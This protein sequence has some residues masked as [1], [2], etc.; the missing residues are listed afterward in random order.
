MTLLQDRPR[1]P[2]AAAPA[3]ASSKA[4]AILLLSTGP[5]GNGASSGSVEEED[6][7]L[8]L[9]MMSASVVSSCQWTQWTCELLPVEVQSRNSARCM[10][11]L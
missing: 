6:I 10:A 7:Q 1:I 11:G 2:L 4:L 8:P 5:I 9:S 3:T